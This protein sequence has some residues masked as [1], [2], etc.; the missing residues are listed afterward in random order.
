MTKALIFDCDGVLAETERDG[1]RVAFNAMFEEFG[2]PVRWDEASYARKVQIAGGKERL[3]SLLTPEFVA[4][5]GL[6]AAGPA[7]DEL[8]ARWHKRKT[9]IYG[10]LV[11]GGAIAPRTG[12]RRLARAA[13]D[14][15]WR[16]AV[17]STSAEPSVLA[18]LERAAGT[19]LAARFAVFAGDVV[20][21]KKPAPD[22]YLHVLDALNVRH[23]RAAVIEDS[24]NGVSSA[25][26]AGIGCLV[27]LSEYSGQDDVSGA[28]IVVSELGDPG[29]PPVEVLAN[30]THQP[31]RGYIT[32][33]HIEAISRS[34]IRRQ[35]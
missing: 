16:L 32:L 28:Q 8:V 11:A 29:L 33:A 4:Q 10:D 22:I 26:A 2:L 20:R 27:T 23:G 13:D 17:A 6:P 3:R 5:A 21:H 24:G 1:H 12:V 25:R 18:V 30:H 34:P 7:L 31:V 19:G 15:G 14:A 9:E 35:W